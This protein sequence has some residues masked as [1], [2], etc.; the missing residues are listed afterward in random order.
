VSGQRNDEDDFDLPFVDDDAS[1]G[2]A[3]DS[4]EFDEKLKKLP[5]LLR[6]VV[7]GA[8]GESFATERLIADIEELAPGLVQTSSFAKERD[9]AS[10]LELAS[11]LD[12]RAVCSDQP[13][14]RGLADCVRLSCL[15]RPRQRESML[16]YRRVAKSL[17]LAN[18][19]MPPGADPEIAAEI[20]EFCFG[21]AAL[22][23]ATV[24]LPRHWDMSA[25]ANARSLGRLM[26]KRR[27][28]VAKAELTEG[29]DEEMTLARQRNARAAAENVAEH[30]DAK[31]SAEGHVIVCRMDEKAMN[32]TRMRETI[33]PFRHV[34]NVP[35]PLAPVPPL[36][37]VRD[38]LRREFPYALE[39]ID[40]ALTGLVGRLTVQLPAILLVGPPGSGKTRFCRRLGELLGIS[41]WGCD[42]SQS[43]GANF[44]GTGRR[45]HS[46]EPCHPFL[47]VARARQ[48]NPMVVIDEIEKA[49]T[50]S[51]YGRLWDALLGF[52]EPESAAR[53]PDPALQ[54][55]L[56]L[57][58]ISY[59]ATANSIYALP[60]PLA[61]RFR[62]VH[63]PRPR[64]EDL[65]GLLPAVVADLAAQRGLDLRWVAPLDGVER[66]AV[67]RNWR[68]QSVRRLRRIVEAV[69][70]VRETSAIRN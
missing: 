60:T 36:I 66:D 12:R 40:F 30:I 7:L 64:S 55:A 39:V 3:A 8:R 52:L 61:D 45:W 1:T 16:D 21:W 65:D 2:A 43:D 58:H 28:A 48:A 51:D 44:A 62:I 9:T 59:L 5:R 15:P 57:S 22:S 13:D 32:H 56:D 54:A 34:I 25:A 24:L 33:E 35:L 14:L 68:G 4:A 42:S 18:R 20:E 6:Y 38:S 10:G 69:L 31:G 49:A 37:D 47:A 63:F 23:N 26:A 50:R 67:A 11:A 70:L 41:V 27:L 17:L 46:T 53:Y 29:F 19:Q